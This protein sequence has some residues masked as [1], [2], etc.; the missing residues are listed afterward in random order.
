MS[1]NFVNIKK[2]DLPKRRFK[3]ERRPETKIKK[4]KKKYERNQAK[5]NTRKR[6]RNETS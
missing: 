5:A 1:K 4:S 6:I 2:K 3:W